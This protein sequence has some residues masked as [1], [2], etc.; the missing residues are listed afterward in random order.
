M[1]VTTLW[2][3]CLCAI[4]P[5]SHTFTTSR[6]PKAVSDRER[7]THDPVLT[8]AATMNDTS[9]TYVFEDIN[10]EFP[11]R[12]GR[13]HDPNSSSYS[14]G[15]AKKVDGSPSSPKGN[16]PEQGRRHP[17]AAGTFMVTGLMIVHS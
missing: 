9:D 6:L 12:N 10:V 7:G 17:A 8:E 11:V 5:S 4:L 16:G 15:S 13:A 2:E 14:N 1:P 3:A